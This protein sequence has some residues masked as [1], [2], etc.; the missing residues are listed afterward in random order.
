[1]QEKK[2]YIYRYI[3]KEQLHIGYK[4]ERK[5]SLIQSC[6]SKKKKNEHT[7]SYIHVNNCSCVLYKNG[8]KPINECCN[9]Q[10]KTHFY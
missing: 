2:K 7:L 4:Y 3:R 9:F 5:G 8:N 6:P 1:M 10:L